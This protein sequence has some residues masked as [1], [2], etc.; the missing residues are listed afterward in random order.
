M[1][2]NAPMHHMRTN[3]WQKLHFELYLLNHPLDIKNIP[4]NIMEVY[5]TKPKVARLEKKADISA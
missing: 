4:W 2:G 3:C 5:V 1:T